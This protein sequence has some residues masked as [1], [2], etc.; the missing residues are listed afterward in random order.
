MYKFMTT[1]DGRGYDLKD[2]VLEKLEAV[3]TPGSL[4]LLTFL[5]IGPFIA[6]VNRGEAQR[7]QAQVEFMRECRADGKKNYECVAMWRAGERRDT[8]VVPMPIVVPR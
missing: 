6:A 1:M 4:L 5:G 7:R 3:F 8:T 2:R